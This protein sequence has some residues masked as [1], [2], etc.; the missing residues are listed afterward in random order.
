MRG[1]CASL[2]GLTLGPLRPGLLNHNVYKDE[3][4]IGESLALT[5]T[6]ATLAAALVYAWT[7]PHYRRDHELLH[8]AG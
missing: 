7:R 4:A 1:S 8:P 2:G 5:L 6:F 3:S